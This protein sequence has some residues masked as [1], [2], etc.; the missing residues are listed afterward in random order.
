MSGFRRGF[1]AKSPLVLLAAALLLVPALLAFQSVFVSG[2]WTNVPLE[3]CLLRARDSF[4]YVSWTVG[5][6]K[7]AP[8]EGPAAYLLGG[9][10]AREAIVSGEDLAADVARLGGPAI[11][12][13]DLGSSNQNFAQSLAVIDN[14]PDTPAWVLIGVNL[15]RFT[16]DKQANIDQV[17]GRGFLLKSPALERFAAE[18][19][20]TRAR[21]T[22][23]LPG[24]SA[25]LTDIADQKVRRLRTGKPLSIP[26]KQHAF[27][28]VDQVRKVRQKERYVEVWNTR[29]YPVFRRNLQMNLR[30]L[31][32]LLARSQERGLRVV[33][34]ELPLNEEIVRGRFDYAKVKYQRPVQKLARRYDVPY[35][36]FNDE[37]AI[38]NASFFDLSHMI[39]SGSVVW[40]RQLAR[41][42]VRLMAAE[43]D[44]AS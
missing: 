10:S 39:E 22:T 18:E 29:Q 30:V 1:R 34:V 42:L 17:Q 2:L 35:L 41:E 12:A 4:T 24:I 28:T 37:V 27:Y 7:Q 16:P 38:P 20:G 19:W 21:A 9:S 23:I 40:Q 6:A 8:P 15:G 14:L 3:R 13:Y 5:R 44:A 32:A 11:T 26:Y 43:A 36:D 33:F 25:Y 31:E